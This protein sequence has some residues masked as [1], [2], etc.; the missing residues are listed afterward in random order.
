MNT[1]LLY[2][3]YGM[4]L[5]LLLGLIASRIQNKYPCSRISLSDLVKGFIFGS[6]GKVLFDVMLKKVYP[7][8]KLLAIICLSFF[9]FGLIF[10][11]V[12]IIFRE[13][14]KKPNLNEQ[15]KKQ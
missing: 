6:V 8:N 9:A 2:G 14:S 5:V 13:I 12:S 10:A 15:E 7:T 4:A 3:F 11:Y 1:Y